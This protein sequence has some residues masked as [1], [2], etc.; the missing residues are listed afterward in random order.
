MNTGLHFSSEAM[1]WGTPQALFDALT[2]KFNFTLDAC[3]TPENAKCARFITPEQDALTS[4]WFLD[5]HEV[6]FCNPP[7]GRKLLPAFVRRAIDVAKRGEVVLLVPA[8]TDTNWFRSAFNASTDVLFIDKRVRF[9]RGA[10][11]DAAPFPSAVLVLAPHP[12]L[13]VRR[14]RC[15][16]V[17]DL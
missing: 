7:Y 12:H 17:G 8:R 9:V 16:N 15:G 11:T 5:E 13:Y 14:V 2:A 6:A 4:P 3:A 1:D 10:C